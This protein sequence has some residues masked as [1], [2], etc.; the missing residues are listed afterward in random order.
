[1]DS[2]VDQT[3][4]KGHTVS[5][6]CSVG[7]IGDKAEEQDLRVRWKHEG[8]A[9]DQKSDRYTLTDNGQKLILRD[10]DYRD[11]GQYTCVASIRG[12]AEREKSS[13]RL[14]VRGKCTCQGYLQGSPQPDSMSEV[15]VQVRGPCAS[16]RSVYKSKVRVRVRHLCLKSEVH[17]QVRHVYKS[18]ICVQVRGPCTSLRSVYKSEVCVQVRGT[19]TSL[20]S[21]YRSEIHVQVRGLC[22]SQRSMYRSDICVQVRYEYK[23]EVCVQVRSTCTS[24]RHM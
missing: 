24:Q 13:A 5:F 19:C 22:T 21:V 23:L 2:L 3:V 10:V 7:F 18:D 11:E 16:Q 9:L 1:M 15:Y 20:R 12:Q 14:R 17:V 4:G 6:T 8:E